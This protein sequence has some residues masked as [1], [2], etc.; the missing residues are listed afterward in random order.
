MTDENIQTQPEET[1][2]E[3]AVYEPVFYNPKALMRLADGASIAAWIVAGVYLI[4]IISVILGAVKSSQVSYLLSGLNPLVQG[5]FYFFVLKGI[6]VGLYVLM[7]FEL[8]S[9]GEE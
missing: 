5:V 1:P 7:E 8:N 6:S 3:E 4:E 2:I 9:R